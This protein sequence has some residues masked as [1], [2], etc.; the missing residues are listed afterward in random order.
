MKE[1]EKE[2]DKQ[3]QAL[4]D[5]RGEPVLRLEFDVF[6][7]NMVSMWTHFDHGADFHKVKEQLQAI[8]NHLAEFIRDRNMC[9][10]HKTSSPT[11]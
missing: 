11:T 4:I 8:E 3:R 9:P 2:K 7:G 1:K 6:E 5:E 10:F